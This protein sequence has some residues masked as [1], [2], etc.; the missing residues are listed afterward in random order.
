[1]SVETVKGS[2]IPL[3]DYA[4]K[5]GVSLSTLRRRIK[6]NKVQYKLENGK[7]L[8]FDDGKNRS[9]VPDRVHRIEGGSEEPIKLQSKLQKL[10]N[11]LQKAQI[12]IAELKTL[13]AL[14]EE[15]M[16]NTLDN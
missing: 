15:Q 13:I 4:M 3:M 6:A 10:E 2:W 16:P 8:L 11:D 14:Y 1:M 5:R 9:R 12:E 7:Y